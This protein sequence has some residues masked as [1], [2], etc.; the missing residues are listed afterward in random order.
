MPTLKNI[1]TCF[2]CEENIDHRVIKRHLAKCLENKSFIHPAEKENVFLIKIY[3]GKFFWLYIAI[4]GR[5]KLDRLD[6][7][8]R[9]IWLECC[10]HLSQFTINGEYYDCDGGM[11]K[12]LHRLFNVGTVFDYEYDFGSTTE[13]K[14]EVIGMYPGK[15]KDDIE[16]IARNNL[17]PHLTCS[18]CTKKPDFICSMCL[19]LSCKQ[20]A[21]N[22]KCDS[23]YDYM[24]PVVNSPRMGV[25]GY[26][27]ED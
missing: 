18:K 1:G 8:L 11:N 23:G 20:C 4:N 26:T 24:L 27:G 25:C 12:V 5:C 2:L 6:F 22:D 19:E 10:G 14:G 3:A 7:F 17:P 16:L 13:L 9:S 15:L 21:K